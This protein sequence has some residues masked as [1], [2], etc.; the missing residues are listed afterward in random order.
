MPPEDSLPRKPK[1]LE[2]ARH[3][4]RANY[5]SRRTEEVYLGSMR[6]FIL[7]HGKQHPRELREPAVAAFLSHLTVQRR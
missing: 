2:R 5:Y 6:R 3:L 4:L 1:L 7:F